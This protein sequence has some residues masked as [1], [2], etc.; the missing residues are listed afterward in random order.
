VL[1]AVEERVAAHERV[2]AGGEPDLGGSYAYTPKIDSEDGGE[3]H[4]AG[5]DL[6]YRYTPLSQASYRGLIWGTEFL[7]NRE[8]QPVGG[9]PAEPTDVPLVFKYRD[10]VG[11]YS[12]VEARVSRRFAPGFLF[13]YVQDVAGIEPS[14]RAYSPYLT[15][16]AS[17]FERLRLQYTYLDQPHDHENQFFVQWTAILGSHVHGFRDR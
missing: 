4:L 9:F 10:A 16:W 1:G 12:Y 5:A 7:Y 15:I 3:R 6:T 14:T 13:D 17:E 2:D 11:L 8:E